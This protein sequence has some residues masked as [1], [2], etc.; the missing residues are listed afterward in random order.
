M[1]SLMAVLGLI[2]GGINFLYYREVVSDSDDTLEFLM[3]NGGTFPKQEWENEKV[4][5]SPE[6]PYESRYFSVDLSEDGTVQS[7]DTGQIAAVDFSMA[8]RYAKSILKS[9]KTQGFVGNYRY[10]VSD[11]VDKVQI[12]FLD[13]GRTLS[14][15]WRFLVISVWMAAFGLV[16]VFIL[17][18]LFSKRIIR[19]MSENYEKQK[20]FITDAGHEIKTPLTI[21]DADADVLEMELGEN[22]WLADIRNQ[23]RRM[24]ALTNDLIYLS[25]MEEA[26]NGMP[27]IDFPL[28]DVT[29]EVADSFVM[30]AKAQN[31][32]FTSSIEPYLTLHGDEKSIR[33]LISVLLDN[34]LRY[35]D[36][37]GVIS[38]ELEKKGRNI[39]LS[40]YNTTAH[41]SQEDTAHLF[42]RFYRSD[43]SRN[44][45]T[46]GYGIGLS[47]ASAVVTAHKGKITAATK[48]ERSLLITAVFPAGG[49]HREKERENDRRSLLR[50]RT[51]A[52][53]TGG[54]PAFGCDRGV[55]V[56]GGE[57]RA[58]QPASD[59]VLYFQDQVAGKH[60]GKIKKAGASRQCKDSA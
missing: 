49:A 12:V 30:M 10:L 58:G 6:L 59:P 22:E 34:A 37:E 32:K 27:M 29:E 14:G 18:C 21:I 44:S 36:P 11:D 45:D 54:T 13:C 50:R 31:K 39:R 42:E 56:S 5:F 38:L 41:I 26:K 20:R 48:D 1:C 60:G 51:K 55:S 9:G 8:V 3:E 40:V 2:L 16:A 43:K 35:A 33:Q 47:I 57:R 15:F 28:S 7:S 23:T 17:I 46:G 53:K 4:A 19:P 24:T 52:L 25:R